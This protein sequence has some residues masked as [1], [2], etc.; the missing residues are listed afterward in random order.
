MPERLYE[1]FLPRQE[2]PHPLIVISPALG[3]VFF[4]PDLFFEKQMA[5]FFTKHGFATAVVH[6][7]FFNIEREGGLGQ[8]DRYLEDSVGKIKKS[9]DELV[10][11]EDIDKNRVVSL[12][13]SFGGMVNILFAAREPR[14]KAHVFAL[15]GA[16]IPEILTTSRDP[17]VRLY[18]HQILDVCGLGREEFVRSLKAS[19][20]NEP[21]ESARKIEPDSVLM[22]IAR[23]DHVVL[24]IY[25][26][27][28][29]E[30]L[31]KPETLFLP[32]G[33]YFTI[34]LLPYLERKALEFFRRKLG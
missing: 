32:V 21:F 5:R 31:R 20:Q 17:L 18:C 10:Q 33:H 6:R 26:K 11:R 25:S 12:G 22:I 13:V 23:F 19:L 7:D 27:L 16:N 30:A 1:L 8:V 29:W 2:G 3:R 9:F 28:L 14:I 24:P 15:A 34:L 4:L